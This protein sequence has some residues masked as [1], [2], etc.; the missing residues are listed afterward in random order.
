MSEQT[1][2]PDNVQTHGTQTQYADSGPREMLLVG[3]PANLVGEDNMYPPPSPYAG[4]LGTRMRRGYFLHS[5]RLIAQLPRRAD[6]FDGIDDKYDLADVFWDVG[7]VTAYYPMTKTEAVQLTW[8]YKT[9]DWTL[10]TVRFDNYVNDVEQN[11]HM[12]LWQNR[13][14]F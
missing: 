11:H 14:S 1:A 10:E 3:V 5:G 7:T 12:T 2:N 4:E 9:D 6:D 8:E 13:R